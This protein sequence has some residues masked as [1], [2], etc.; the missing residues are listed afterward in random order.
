[1]RRLQHAYDAG[2]LGVEREEVRRRRC[3]QRGLRLDGLDRL[4][5]RHEDSAAA[6][7][8]R[9]RQ[10]ERPRDTAMP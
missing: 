2:V 4:L 10:R 9:R 5:L 8:Q 3:G 7:R 1:M 6:K